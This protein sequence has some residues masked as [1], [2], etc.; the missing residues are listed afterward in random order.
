MSVTVINDQAVAAVVEAL[1]GHAAVEAAYLLGS[2]AA[3]TLRPDSDIDIA[4]LPRA[5]GGISPP[6]RLALTAELAMALG[7][8]IDLGVLSTANVVYAKEAVSTGRVLFERDHGVT[9]RFAMLVLSMYASLQE[10]RRE[11][12]EAY[13]A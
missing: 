3:G 10:A 4:V 1:R 9:A 2:A 6:E 12:L 7:R 8:P 13:A 11:V 5:S